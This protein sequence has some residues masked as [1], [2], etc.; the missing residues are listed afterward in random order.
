MRI[1]LSFGWHGYKFYFVTDN[2]TYSHGSNLLKYS[3]QWN[4]SAALQGSILSQ[5]EKLHAVVFAASSQASPLCL[6][7]G[8]S[9]QSQSSPIYFSKSVHLALVAWEKTIG[10]HREFSQA[11]KVKDAY[12][13]TIDQLGSSGVPFLSASTSQI[14]R[15]ELIL[16]WHWRC[17]AICMKAGLCEPLCMTFPHKIAEGL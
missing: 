6:S 17:I 4:N 9:S 3:L 7:S 5:L 13:A 1:Y 10:P 16:H 2:F 11:T 15:G 8:I 14:H 12:Q